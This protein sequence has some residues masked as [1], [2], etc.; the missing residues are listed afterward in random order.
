[1]IEDHCRRLGG[2]SNVESNMI[3]IVICWL[4]TNN[5]ILTLEMITTLSGI[6]KQLRSAQKRVHSS[7][8]ID[9]KISSF[10]RNSI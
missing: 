3:G 5:N 2:L 6:E 7:V 10:L 9:V 4:T 8:V 1:M